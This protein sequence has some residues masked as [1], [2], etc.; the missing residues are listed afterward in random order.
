M[1]RVL[2]VDDS[3]YNR[4]ALTRMLSQHPEIEVIDTARNGED[5]LKKIHNAKPDVIT[6]DLEM[7]VMDGFSV[8]RWLQQNQPTPVIV[9]SARASDA[10]VF[11]ALELGAVDFIAKPTGK[12]SP[13]LQVIATDL[14]AKVK[15]AS[16]AELKNAPPPRTPQPVSEEK[17]ER[18][19]GDYD[20]MVIGASTGGPAAIQSII[21]ALPQLSIPI[22]VA[23]HMPP[24]FTQLFAERMDRIA[25]MTVVEAKDGQVAE[26]GVVYISPGG[27]HISIARRGSDFHLHILPRMI[28]D[29]YAPSVDVLFRSAAKACGG[30][31]LAVLLTGMGSDGAQ[32]LKIIL[33][34]GGTTLVESEQSAVVFGMPG[35]AVRLGAAQR[36]L[37]LWEIPG[38]II[39]IL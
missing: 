34:Q 38:E 4:M 10:N 11:K 19:A 29:L 12:A 31:I 32:G 36:I 25:K 33:D 7:P 30:R 35:E 26:P 3:A 5:A 15:A 9:V 20:C 24:I 39:K 17:A 18:K 2:V 28:D 22:V 21:S 1:I 27:S 6:L 16:R 13:T 8:L 23:Q 37:P 14:I